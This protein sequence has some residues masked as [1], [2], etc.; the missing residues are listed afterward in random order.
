M[1]KPIALLLGTLLPLLGLSGI[2]HAQ[3]SIQVQGTIQSVD[4]QTLA[5]V[6]RDPGSGISNT[7]VAAPDTPVLVGSTSIAFCALEQYIG[8]PAGAWLVASGNE[9]VA[10]RI[11]VFGPAAAAPPPVV[12]IPQPVPVPEPAPAEV[13]SPL[14]IVGIVLGTIIVAG[15]V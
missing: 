3:P 12:G 14:P 11:D 2:G 1:R 7:I 4:C 9:F 10:T 5:V 6:L 8:A 13:A 15:L